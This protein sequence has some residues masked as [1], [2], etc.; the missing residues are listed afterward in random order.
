MPNG[1]YRIAVS[2]DVGN[3][4]PY[5]GTEYLSGGGYKSSFYIVTTRNGYPNTDYRDI[6][7]RYK[8]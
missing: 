5:A 2:V 4:I 3:V 6:P 1:T 7:W 8:Y